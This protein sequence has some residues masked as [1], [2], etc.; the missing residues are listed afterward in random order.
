[1][2]GQISSLPS[3][4]VI[5]HTAETKS[6][7]HR[8]LIQIRYKVGGIEA[9]HENPGEVRHEFGLLHREQHQVRVE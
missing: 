4:K 6:I 7:N 5:K 1:M 2:E 8:T 9:T 3:H